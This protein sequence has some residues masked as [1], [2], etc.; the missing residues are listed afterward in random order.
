[1]KLRTTSRLALALAL[2]LGVTVPLA[3]ANAAPTSSSSCFWIR[4][5]DNFAS[6]DT[7][8]VYVR[9]NGRQVYEL[10]LFAPCLD[11]NWSHHIG[12]RSRGSSL[13][14]EGTRHN[15]EIIVRS[16]A[17]RQ[18]C[19]VTSVRRLTPDEVSALPKGARP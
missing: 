10:K 5:V 17:H 12:L 6:V 7:S 16:T 4:S 19:P 9:A 14:C 3:S 15:V 2:G 1:M 18:H 8:T 13:I 11:V